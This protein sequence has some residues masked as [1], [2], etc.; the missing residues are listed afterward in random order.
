MTLFSHQNFY[1]CRWIKISDHISRSFLNSNIFLT[2][3]FFRKMQ[4]EFSFTGKSEN[5]G[6][7]EEKHSVFFYLSF[8]L[9][10]MK[11]MLGWESI[12]LRISSLSTQIVRISFAI[13]PILW[14]ALRIFHNTPICYLDIGYTPNI[15]LYFFYNVRYLSSIRHLQNL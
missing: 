1:F 6:E 3:I 13:L 11:I 9:D 4:S 7:G 8:N 2:Q 12:W 5:W 10:Q 14:H 15:L